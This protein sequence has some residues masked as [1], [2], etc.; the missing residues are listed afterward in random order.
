[1]TWEKFKTFLEKNLGDSTSFV[2]N[3]WSKI[4]RD[5]FYQYEEVQD[6]VSNLEHFQ[7]I[8]IE[9]DVKYAPSKYLLVWYIYESLKPPIKLWIDKKSQKLDI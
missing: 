9:L 2:D 8:H 7:S 1:M 3:I 4:K 6:W 5:S